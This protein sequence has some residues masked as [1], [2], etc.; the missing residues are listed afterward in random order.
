MIKK[1]SGAELEDILDDETA[2]ANYKLIDVR[3]E[4]TYEEGH[5]EGAENIPL[6]KL[7]EIDLPKDENIIV[8]CNGGKTSKKAADLLSALG[9]ENIYDADGVKNYAY[10]NIVNR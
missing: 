7:K 5:I 4:S 3:G 2:R 1:I 8:Y 10:K 9:Y 6:D